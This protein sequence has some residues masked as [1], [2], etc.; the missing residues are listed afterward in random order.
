MSMY[1]GMA[2][3]CKSQLTQEPVR[4]PMLWIFL[5]VESLSAHDTYTDPYM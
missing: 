4:E 5:N 3:T 2:N 1:V